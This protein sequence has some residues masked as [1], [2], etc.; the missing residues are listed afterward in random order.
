MKVASGLCVLHAPPGPADGSGV[1]YGIGV[2]LQIAPNRAA[3]FVNRKVNSGTGVVDFEGGSDA[4]V[5]D[6]LES[7]A[8]A[9]PIPISRNHEEEYTHTDGRQVRL[10]VVKY[11]VTV[12]FV[13]LGALRGDGSPHPH[14]GTGFAIIHAIG[15]E[16]PD[17]STLRDAESM[18]RFQQKHREA[19][20]RRDWP[21]YQYL[22]VQQ[23]L[24]D[25]TALAVTSSER[26]GIDEICPPRTFDGH[27]SLV[28]AI[29]DG[30]DLL[31]GV[32]D[33]QS[34][35]SGVSR[36]VRSQGRWRMV[37]YAPVTRE[38]GGRLHRTLEASVIRAPNGSLLFTP[39]QSGTAPTKHDFRVWRSVDGGHTWA[40]V[41]RREARHEQSPVTLNQAA[42]GRPYLAANVYPLNGEGDAGEQTPER[43][44]YS[45][46]R[47]AIWPLSH[48]FTD[49]LPP[50]MVFDAAALPSRPSDLSWWVDHPTGATIRL[51]DGQWRHILA[52]R[53]I[54][55]AEVRGHASSAPPE[56]GLHIREIE[57]GGAPR[58]PWRFA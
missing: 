57:T 13:P 21:F 8:D 14:A 33:A 31:L 15:F 34:Q 1:A 24:C 22:E 4:I 7:I 29:P 55:E 51:A 2:P 47:L 18:R 6:G 11:P 30:D 39:R 26:F 56:S 32:R 46:A 25:G 41:L 3:C 48:D 10:T 50:Q 12:G 49:V 43:G 54:S 52:F 58:P 44:P 23:H 45:R 27:M 40:E 37:D 36:W 42:D 20:Q 16:M 38:G 53:V 9:E 17:P 35:D 5:F 19:K 28:P